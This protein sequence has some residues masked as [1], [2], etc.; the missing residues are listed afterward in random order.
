[1]GG[2]LWMS[3]TISVMVRIMHHGIFVVSAKGKLILTEGYIEAQKI[4]PTN[5]SLSGRILGLDTQSEVAIVSNKTFN[6]F[7]ESIKA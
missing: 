7:Y 1:M 2:R 5:S 3:I 6:A 4:K